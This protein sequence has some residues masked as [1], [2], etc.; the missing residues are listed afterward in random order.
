MADKKSRE[1][2][3]E[4]KMKVNVDVSDALTALK[5]IQREAKKATQALNE[6]EAQSQNSQIPNHVKKYW[7]QPS[8]GWKH[9]GKSSGVWFSDEIDG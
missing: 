5:A 2:I 3:G 8:K 4:L 1:F 7:E 9:S 6:L